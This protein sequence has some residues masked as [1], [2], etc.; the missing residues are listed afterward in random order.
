MCL[1]HF[2]P[3]VEWLK[4]KPGFYIS[5]GRKVACLRQTHTR[6]PLWVHL[7]TN[8]PG[9]DVLGAPTE[10]A[11]SPCLPSPDLILNK[12][13]RRGS[14]LHVYR[15]L[16]IHALGGCC[17]V[18]NIKEHFQSSCWIPTEQT[19]LFGSGAGA[20]R[21]ALLE[22]ALLACVISPFTCCFEF[23][24]N[25]D[26]KEKVF[27]G[28]LVLTRRLFFSLRRRRRRFILLYRRGPCG[29]SPALEKEEVSQRV[30]TQR[31]KT[32]IRCCI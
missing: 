4:R 23:Y 31:Q 9:S 17:E 26:E 18:L 20:S 12:T 16:Y 27:S 2:V 5:K 22:A 25:W 11:S 10:G 3:V 13:T 14:V 21:C 8:T 24:L 30:R 7:C 1:S 15:A 28:R 19:L 32:S 6:W 29:I